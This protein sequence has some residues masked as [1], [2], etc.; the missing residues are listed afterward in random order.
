[1]NDMTKIAESSMFKFFGPAINMVLSTIII[2]IF[3]AAWGQF[4]LLNSQ[5]S[6][7]QTQNALATQRFENIE[8]RIAANEKFIDITRMSDL[9]QDERLT[10]ISETIKAMLEERRPNEGVRNA[11]PYLPRG[12]HSPES[13]N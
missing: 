1:M 6:Q 10:T 3:V 11:R 9:R 4:T 5:I 8:R 2:G 7:W 12:M 13:Q